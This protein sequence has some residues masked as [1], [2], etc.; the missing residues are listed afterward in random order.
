MSRVIIQ[1]P[2]RLNSFLC[3]KQIK[4]IAFTG[5][6]SSG[7]TF[8]AK[9][10]D[11]ILSKRSSYFSQDNYYRDFKKD[12]SGKYSLEE[13]YQNINF[14][15]PQHFNISKLL[16]DLRKIKNITNLQTVFLPKI[17]FGTDSDFPYSIENGTSLLIKEYVITEGVYALKYPDYNIEKEYDLK[18][19]VEIDESTRKQ[20]WMKRNQE[21]G[22]YFNEHMWQT[23]VDAYN[24]YIYPTK[25]T[26][27]IVLNNTTPFYDFTDFFKS[28]FL[29]LPSTVL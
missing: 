21:E 25:E 19:F 15:D 14:D 24:K 16:N 12:F 22:R 6:S 4:I 11:S 3:K 9:K 18:I 7:K 5:A 23:T 2:E 26:A 1:N 27:D 10:L 8:L 17:V 13:F 28:T 29:E 20:I